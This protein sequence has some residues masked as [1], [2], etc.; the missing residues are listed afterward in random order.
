MSPRKLA[1]AVLF[2]TRRAQ[3]K[4]LAA[5][6]ELPWLRRRLRLP[7]NEI[8]DPLGQRLPAHVRVAKLDAAE[9]F[10]RPMPVLPDAPPAAIDFFSRR[11][12]EI[13]APS[14]VSE[15]ENGIAW[16]HPTGGVFTADGQFAAAFT[17]DP[18]GAQ[19][20]T[21][22]TR[23]RLPEPTELAGRTL[24][25]VT[26][27]ASDN[28]HH[29][30]IDLLPRLGLVRRAGYDLSAFDHVIV[31]HANR[32]YQ[33]STLTQLGIAPGKIITATEA[34]FV[35]CE[36]LVVPSLK[37]NNQTL[38][39]ADLAFLREAFLK[40]PSSVSS[41]TPHRRI[42]LSRSDARY[43][44]L[45]NEAELHPL[46]RSHNFE[47]VS[48]ASLD[49]L[50]QATLFSEAAVIAGPAGAAFANL[51][52]APSSAHVIEIAPPQWLA[53][54]HWMISARSGLNH[55]ILLGSGPIME[56]IP[57]SSARQSDVAVPPEK[58]KTVLEGLPISPAR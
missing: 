23:M 49:P 4:T 50:A 42:F 24:Y 52:F 58:L 27:E 26:P 22:W 56:G 11:T 12:V 10:V 5:P 54:F 29:W 18:G 45:S 37:P 28:F 34:L 1:K 2:H 30:M 53:A 15:F 44:R 57:D 46:L 13:T 33:L 41:S 31:N 32:S 21:V 7:A 51:V 38:P 3:I 39:A 35:R 6:R 55:T 48:P 40:V 20:H 14:Y 16:G 25:L 36:S 9:T 8:F 19:L 43:R 17:H 47:I